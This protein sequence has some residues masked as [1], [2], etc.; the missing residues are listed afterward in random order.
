MKT[1]QYISL[2]LLIGVFGG[3]QPALG[4]E[5]VGLQNVVLKPGELVWGFDILLQ[6]G[7]IIAV[8]TIPEGWKITV[9]NYGEAAEYKEGGGQVQGD[10]DFGHDA[11]SAT[12]L[13][14]LWGLLLIDR[15]A[16]HGKSAKLTGLITISGP[17]VNRKVQ[18]RSRNFSRREAAQ[19]PVPPAR[20]RRKSQ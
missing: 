17:S 3:V 13:S 14:E 9:E 5:L 2:F 6:E 19:C 7:R 1:L 15:S 8:C 16:V 10:A 11:L 4:A 12:K 18:L 20:S